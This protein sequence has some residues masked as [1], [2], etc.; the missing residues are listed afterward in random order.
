MILNT[1]E[2]PENLVREPS[3]ISTWISSLSI[4]R[5]ISNKYL[6]STKIEPSSKIFNLF[7]SFAVILRWI[8]ISA[9]L[10]VTTIELSSTSIF[11]PLKD[12]CGE[13]GEIA[14]DTNCNVL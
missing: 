6:D 2:L 11:N 12:V 3:I 5:T 13:F 4:L 1:A 8:E 14:L 7:F 9:S 10:P